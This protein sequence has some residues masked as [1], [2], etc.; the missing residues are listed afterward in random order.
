MISSLA[1]HLLKQSSQEKQE[2][3][4]VL[5]QDVCRGRDSESAM[6]SKPKS[7]KDVL[8]EHTM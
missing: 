1:H 5:A 8:I 7:R 3:G 4:H 6:S 2:V